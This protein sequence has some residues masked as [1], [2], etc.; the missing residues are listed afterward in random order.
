[1]IT[2]QFFYASSTVQET[3]DALLAGIR[4]QKGL[5]LVTGERG[6][7]KTTLLRHL[8]E[9]LDHAILSLFVDLTDS[10]SL[11]FD[12]LLEFL[13][14]Q[15][16]L[17]H[18]GP[19]QLRKLQALS[20][21]VTARAA[22]GRM[23][24]LLL[25]A[26]HCLDDE[27]LG[28]LRF[29]I[30]VDKLSDKPLLQIVLAGRPEIDQRLAQ[31]QLRSLEQRIALRCH[32]TRWEERDIELFIRQ[33]QYGLTD[34]QSK[35]FT[36]EAVH[37]IALYS[38]GMPQ[39]VELCC[40]LA[41]R[42]ASETPRQP[43]SATAIDHVIPA[44]HTL[45]LLPEAVPIAPGVS[46]PS[47]WKR[48]VPVFA[49]LTLLA[50]GLFSSWMLMSLPPD[51]VVKLSTSVAEQPQF[52]PPQTTLAPSATLPPSSQ[53]VL[54]S[55]AVEV[56]RQE[57]D[58]GNERSITSSPSPPSTLIIAKAHPTNPNLKLVEGE[59]FTFTIEAIS[60]QPKSLQ[61]L[62][63]LDGKEQARGQRWTYR[64]RFDEGGARR[65]EVTVRMMNQDKL[66]V[67]RTWEVL[68]E[69]VNRPPLITAVFPS[70][71]RLELSASEEQR[72]SI[73]AVDPDEHD[74]L[75]MVW[76]LDGQEVARGRD[77]NL[78]WSKTPGASTQH[79]VAVEVSDRGRLKTHS[80]WQ[81]VIAKPSS[82]SP[83]VATALPPSNQPETPSLADA[84]PAELFID[85]DQVH[86]WL[87]SSQQAWEKK[88]INAL[89]HLGVVTQQNAEQVQRTL[90]AYKSF[91]VVL[92]N[93]DIH[94]HGNHAEVSF[95]R[96]DTVDGRTIPHPGRK[97]FLL[98]RTT[99]GRLI[100]LRG[101]PKR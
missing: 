8:C 19:G 70:A 69:D 68:V 101:T 59:S 84:M 26:A 49:I 2:P 41:L 61:Y 4:E 64:P 28:R 90:A 47:P 7:G 91:Q 95:F 97:L 77:W 56:D 96:I 99:D 88:D 14:R 40:S 67:E 20:A 81:V 27:A 89:V 86:A 82:P 98:N 54:A 29:L 22:Q 10:A 37:R 74:Q 13:C 39:L 33:W 78:S 93:I 85:E 42:A 100:V 30:P 17:A 3:S 65:K 55:A 36:P 73:E 92:Q 18:D 66:T 87:I 58:P 57:T 76:S 46:A 80:A 62:W 32:L 38:Q 15:L 16:E 60:P 75:T 79:R 11:T 44:L 5:L 43:I 9:H 53:E 48:F 1:M 12:A 72:F 31:P 24:V 45:Q 21:Y 63:L 94:I 52:A 6:I 51:T 83:P 71:D 34:V 23:T 35:E 50:F 25:D